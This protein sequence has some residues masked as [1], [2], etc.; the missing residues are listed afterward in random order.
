M[1]ITF[2]ENPYLEGKN[3]VLSDGTFKIA[4]MSASTKAPAVV[5]N[6]EKEISK[7]KS[8]VDKVGSQ[9]YGMDL[10]LGRLGMESIDYYANYKKESARKLK[11][12]P[13]VANKAKKAYGVHDAVILET[14]E[15]V[16]ED[17]QDTKN[18]LPSEEIMNE[19]VV[20]TRMSR[21]ERTNDI[22]PPV[23][24][25]KDVMQRETPINNS[26]VIN[27]PTRLERYNETPFDS[28]INDNNSQPLKENVDVNNKTSEITGG[29]PNLYNKLIHGSEEND[30]SIRLQDAK[31]K[32]YTAKEE[33][34]KAK[35]VNANLEAEVES[36]RKTIEK[37]KRERKELEERE[38]S[39]TLNM[40]Q[41]TKEEILGETRKYDNLQEELAE[42]I[43]QRDSLINNSSFSKEEKYS[44]SRV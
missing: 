6:W 7:M 12:N 40:L 33:R 35:A 25:Y 39:N 15:E 32:L 8:I 42:L 20:D 26:N 13:I 22:E 5:S 27:T 37:I 29:D 17:K 43:R 36:V 11:V 9:S 19:E 4:K 16:F 2:E 41:A 3:I 14:K 1:D 18:N 34:E 44:R 31:S 24:D 30:V 21:L 23:N 38:L 28:L 10:I